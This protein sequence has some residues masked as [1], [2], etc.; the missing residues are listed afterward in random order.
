MESIDGNTCSYTKKSFAC[1]RRGGNYWI[2]VL[3]RCH[4]EAGLVWDAKKNRCKM[5]C[6]EGKAWS[7]SYKKCGWTKN[8]RKCQ[9]SLNGLY[10]LR[11]T[12]SCKCA[13]GLT[14]TLNLCRDLV[15]DMR[16]AEI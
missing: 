3:G 12:R 8:S 16:A 13:E 2:R 11:E 6:S 1:Q 4:C 7:N 9:Q 15:A 5:D 10:F 14:W